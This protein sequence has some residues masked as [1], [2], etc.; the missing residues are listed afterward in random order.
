VLLTECH[1]AQAEVQMPNPL[2]GSVQQKTAAA[3]A[4]RSQR[5]SCIYLAPASCINSA[6]Y[7]IVFVSSI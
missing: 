3:K 4:G 1:G 6:P 5:F 7:Q 2:G